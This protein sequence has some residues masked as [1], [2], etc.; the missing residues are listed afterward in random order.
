MMSTISTPAVLQCGWAVTGLPRTGA[1]TPA[2][3]EPTLITSAERNRASSMPPPCKPLVKRDSS[4]PHPEAQSIVHIS[5]LHDLHFLSAL[6]KWND[7]EL[8][9]YNASA[10]ARLVLARVQRK[11]AVKHQTVE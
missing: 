8:T 7:R 11:A 5:S 4:N 10:L 3:L 1:I 9:C 6:N 2:Y